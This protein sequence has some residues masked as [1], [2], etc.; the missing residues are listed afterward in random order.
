[1]L[2]CIFR[3]HHLHSL[4][5]VWV[6]VNPIYC[7]DRS[8]EYHRQLWLSG[9]PPQ[10]QNLLWHGPPGYGGSGSNVLDLLQP[11]ELGGL[12]AV[13]PLTGWS[14]IH[15][16]G[17]YYMCVYLHEFYTWLDCHRRYSTVLVILCCL[18]L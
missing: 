7:S 18:I 5:Q 2:S 3:L 9:G 4:L 13:R 11:P 1:M 10:L 6:S 16:P 14:H 12:E 15:I 17:E 8:A